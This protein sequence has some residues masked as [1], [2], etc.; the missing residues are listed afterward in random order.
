MTQR[1]LGDLVGVENT[2]VSRWERGEFRPGPQSLA[3]LAEAF[4]VSEAW[5]VYGEAD[6]ETEVAEPLPYPALDEF[7]ETPVGKGVTDDELA[8]LQ[9]LRFHSGSPS[10]ESYYHHLL[11]IRARTPDDDGDRM[12]EAATASAE[13]RGGKRVRQKRAK[14]S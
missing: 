9:R 4:G 2:E 8:E 3:K 14:H 13:R 6:A 12:T 10:V 1:K 7:L 5:L 11:S